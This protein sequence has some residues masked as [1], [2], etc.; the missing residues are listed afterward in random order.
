MLEV[1][2]PEVYLR[3][4]MNQSQDRASVS[5]P[6]R[7]WYQLIADMY[8][9]TS[10]SVL[11]YNHKTLL[12]KKRLQSSTTQHRILDLQKLF[13]RSGPLGTDLYS[14]PWSFSYPSANRRPPTAF[15]LSAGL[16]DIL[17]LLSL[18]KDQPKTEYTHT[19]TLSIDELSRTYSQFIQTIRRTVH[20]H[21][22]AVA[23]AEATQLSL[24]DESY[25]YISAPST[26][27]IFLL[28]L[29]LPSTPTNT[30]YRALQLLLRHAT[31][32]ILD[33]LKF[34]IGDKNTFILDATSWLT[35]N[36]DFDF[37]PNLDAEV[38]DTLQFTLS[39]TGHVKFAYHLSLH[40]CRVM[41][42]RLA[43]IRGG[44]AFERRGEYTGNVYLPAQADVEKV[45]EER[46]MRGV[47]DWLGMV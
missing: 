24:H 26:L 29:P 33:D 25:Q 43:A 20:R 38:H 34:H 46:K 21:P 5:M 40:L 44:C 15:I 16:Q 11:P 14:H 27:P 31:T 23:A 36:D 32:K 10:V 13:F 12:T 4:T 22:V 47:K 1:V 7:A 18:H 6:H 2:M 28:I 45:I 37:P 8:K 9:N 35:D 39:R 3:T 30:T 42:G 19:L 17:D 41:R